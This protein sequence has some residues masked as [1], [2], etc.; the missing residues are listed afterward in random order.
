M[1]PKLGFFAVALFLIGYYAL[2]YYHEESAGTCLQ[3]KGIKMYGTSW[4]PYCKEEKSVLGWHKNYVEF[5]DC[6]QSKDVC[7]EK[8]ISGYPT[9]LLDDGT[10]LFPD[11]LSNMARFT[12]CVPES[13][14]L[15]ATWR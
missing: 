3:A 9:I 13:E 4:C 5:I 12:A 11:T 15:R 10:Q 8:H 2:T 6:D 1:D 14:R 7:V